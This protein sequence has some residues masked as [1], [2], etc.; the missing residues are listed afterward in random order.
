[1]GGWVVGQRAQL[2]KVEDTTRRRVDGS[3]YNWKELLNKRDEMKRDGRRG[4]K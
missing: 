1:M 3:R 4:R 2:R